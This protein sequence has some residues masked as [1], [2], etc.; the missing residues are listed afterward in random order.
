MSPDPVI[1]YYKQFVD[2]TLIREN[3]KKTHEERLITLQRA[4][5]FMEEVR[6]AGEAM[7]H[8]QQQS[9]GEEK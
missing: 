2:L 6:A 3:L 7:R 5:D 4:L 1:E 9:R 8:R